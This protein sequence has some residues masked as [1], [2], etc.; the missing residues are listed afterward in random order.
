[1]LYPL[2]GRLDCLPI[3]ESRPSLRASRQHGDYRAIDRVS[4][5]DPPVV[6]PSHLHFLSASLLLISLT[7]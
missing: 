5:I 3:D 1:M 7:T 6:F 4:L 2:L